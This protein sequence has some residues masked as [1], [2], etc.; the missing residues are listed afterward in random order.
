M[1]P[2]FITSEQIQQWRSDFRKEPRYLQALNAVCANP[3]QKVLRNREAVTQTDF[4]FSHHLPE[5]KATAQMKSGRC[6]LFAA[7]NAL[8]YAAI[9]QLNVGEDF[10]LS[11]NYLMFWDK[12]E[13]SNYF[14]EA[15]LETTAEPLEGRLLHHLLED[16]LQDGG[17]WHMFVNLIQKYGAV[18]KQIMPETESSANTY[19]LNKLL[20]GKLREFAHRLREES[21][22]GGTPEAL[23]RKKNEMLKVIYRILAIHL[24]EPPQSFYWQWRD[25]EKNFHRDGEITPQEFYKRYVSVDLSDYVCLIHCPQK[26]KQFHEC[27]TIRYLGNVMGGEII[28]YLNVELDII[29]NAAVQ[30]LLSGESVWFGSDVGH[31]FDRELGIFDVNIYDFESVFETSIKLNKAERLDYG[32]SKMNHA[33]LFTGVDLDERERPRK[34][35][36]EN[37]WGDQLGDKGFM[38]MTDLW[39]DEYTYEVVVHKRFV[40]QEVLDLLKK[41][42][43]PL[44]PWDPMGALAL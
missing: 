3:I 24:G 7:Q 14:L 35:R 38:V 41:D 12:L 22:K 19:P 29:K 26:S 31:A 43:I 25:K 36:V 1:Q 30:Q 13:R 42:P 21:Q 8:R 39:F 5:N 34:W 32:Q 16:P 10:E 11:P 2:L 20:T 28:R 6:W 40:S 27:Y 33:M 4:S 15:I 23:Q 37:S 18:P 44:D 9:R 17:Q